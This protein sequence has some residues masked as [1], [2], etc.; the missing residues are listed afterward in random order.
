MTYIL[1]KLG[2][3][4]RTLPW[5]QAR[6]CGFTSKTSK[7]SSSCL[8]I[9]LNHK[10]RPQIDFTNLNWKFFFQQAFTVSSQLSA[11]VYLSS[12]PT[13]RHTPSDCLI[14]CS[15]WGWTRTLRVTL[16][17]TMTRVILMMHSQ[18]LH[19]TRSLRFWQHQSSMWSDDMI[20][21][22][23]STDGFTIHFKCHKTKSNH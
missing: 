9:E 1:Y 6:L 5:P 4:E 11:L 20:R 10:K 19:L 15:P 14:V 16:M 3:F 17:Q 23:Y 18:S 22:S 13:S 12:H 21:L 7:T 8:L 2:A